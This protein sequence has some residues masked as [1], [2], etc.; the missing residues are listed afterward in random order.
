MSRPDTPPFVDC[1]NYHQQ[2]ELVS[3][4]RSFDWRGEVFAA[5]VAVLGAPVALFLIGVCFD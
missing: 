5:V 4:D 2:L 3:R 1:R